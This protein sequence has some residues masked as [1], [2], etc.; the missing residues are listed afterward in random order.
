MSELSTSSNVGDDDQQQLQ[1]TSEATAS[2]PVG[3]LQ[4]VGESTTGAVVGSI[5]ASVQVQQPQQLQQQ[6]AAAA[7]AAAAAVQQHQ[8]QL[9]TRSPTKRLTNRRYLTIV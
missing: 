2:M 5:L 3:V 1:I 7:A 6:T 9:G 4:P 8:Q